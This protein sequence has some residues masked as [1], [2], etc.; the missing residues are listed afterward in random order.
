[1]LRF[2][3]PWCFLL[4]LISCSPNNINIDNSLKKYFE[5]NKVQGC[6]AL[7]NNG[8]GQFTLYN[9]ERYRDSSF[10]PLET[11]DIVNALVG[12]QT[13]KISNDSM[14]IKWDEMK[15]SVPEWNRDHS[16]YQAFRAGVVPYFQQVARSIGKDTLQF[17]MDSLSYGT[18]KIKGRIDSFWLDNSLKISPDEQLG[19]VKKLYFNQLPFYRIN[20][21]MIKRAMLFE[22][23]PEY[24]LSYKTGHGVKENGAQLGWMLGYIEENRHPYF[25]VLNLETFDGTL[26]LPAVNMKILKDILNQLGYMKGAR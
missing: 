21:E 19:L 10:L 9:L 20:H 14:I 24:R 23:K 25:F 13:G 7:M 12:L 2:I 3:L 5:E 18:K 22:D 17:W 15:R 6:F 8:T 11:F 16:M 4:A 26:D 1:M